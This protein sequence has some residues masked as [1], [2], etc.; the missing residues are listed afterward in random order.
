V[1]ACVFELRLAEEIFCFA[2]P[3]PADIVYTTLL[4]VCLAKRKTKNVCSV[5]KRYRETRLPIKLL[6]FPLPKKQCGESGLAAAPDK[7]L[8]HLVAISNKSL[9]FISES[10]KAAGLDRFPT[11][12]ITS[13][14]LNDLQFSNHFQYFTATFW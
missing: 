8:Q 6:E 4:S 7:N 12:E 14:A 5:I 10:S 1:C 3:P 9:P 11:G 13:C 2:T